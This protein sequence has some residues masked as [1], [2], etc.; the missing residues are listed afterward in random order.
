MTTLLKQGA[1]GVILKYI[2]LLQYIYNKK[3][4]NKSTV[5]SAIDIYEKL[6]NNLVLTNSLITIIK[7]PLELN[8]V[9]I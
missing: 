9:S 4:I 3:L 1:T 6:F 7:T 5:R 8:N 2:A